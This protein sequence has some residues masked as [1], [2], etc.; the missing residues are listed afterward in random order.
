MNESAIDLLKRNMRGTF[1]HWTA[2]NVDHN[3]C[4]VLMEKEH[5]MR[6]VFLFPQQEP[7]L[8][9]IICQQFQEKN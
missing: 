8:C 2:D 5:F 4:V 1:Q 7:G 6:W 3:T 9:M